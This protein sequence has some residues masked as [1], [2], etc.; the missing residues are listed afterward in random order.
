MQRSYRLSI[1]V[2]HGRNIFPLEKESIVPAL[3][4]RTAVQN[5][6]S[7]TF[8]FSSS[9]EH[10]LQ[11]GN[12]HLK[13]LYLVLMKQEQHISITPCDVSNESLPALSSPE[14]AL[15]LVS[16]KRNAASAGENAFPARSRNCLCTAHARQGGK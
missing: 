2:L 9:T 11:V 6:Y 14:A 4:Y 15:L 10:L 1:E 16:T 5:L 13:R 8:S 7:S 12:S 3:Q